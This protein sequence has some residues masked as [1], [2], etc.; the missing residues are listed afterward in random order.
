[1]KWIFK[2]AFIILQI[3][4]LIGFSST[5]AQHHHVS[6]SAGY[7]LPIE[8]EGDLS[9]YSRHDLGVGA[10][11][12][13][14]YEDITPRFMEGFTLDLGYEYFLSKHWSLWGNL[15]F[16]QSV[17][18][19]NTLHS[20]E[21][22]PSNN[23]AGIQ[24]HSIQSQNYA[25]RVGLALSL[26]QNDR[27]VR[28]KVSERIYV[29]LRVGLSYNEP[30]IIT[31]S[32]STPASPLDEVRAKS[33]LKG[34]GIGG[35]ASFRVALQLNKSINA[36]TQ[37]N[38]E[39]LNYRHTGIKYEYKTYGEVDEL[40]PPENYDFGTDKDLDYYTT[41]KIS[42]NHFSIMIG[43]SYNLGKN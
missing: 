1:M 20:A 24:Q 6:F 21:L 42:L 40:N 4:V 10:N 27:F 35:R 34:Y 3:L 16:T 7:S 29:Q 36:F 32:Q 43:I 17:G 12:L 15:G 8:K 41:Y 39:K 31:T 37:A 13:I 18:Y 2:S 30:N 9:S 26:G 23:Y 22:W 38:F 25:V 33:K 14:V 28:S 19:S 11:G 5:N